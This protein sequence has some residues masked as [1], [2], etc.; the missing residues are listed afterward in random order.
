[1]GVD[2]VIFS[3]E[4]SE[5]VDAEG[6]LTMRDESDSELEDNATTAS[7]TSKVNPSVIER[8]LDAYVTSR[9]SAVQSGSQ[10][11]GN[12]FHDGIV[13]QMRKKIYRDV[14]MNRY[15]GCGNCGA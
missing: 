14:F 1:M 6:D 10:G 3:A 11:G 2:D 5:G 7:G 9:L 12:T 4:R 13:Y 15:D 8:K